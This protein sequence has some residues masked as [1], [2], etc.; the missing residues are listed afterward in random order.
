MKKSQLKSDYSLLS[1]CV[2]FWLFERDVWA[3]PNENVGGRRKKV[4]DDGIFTKNVKG[5]DAAA[6]VDDLIQ[7]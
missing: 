5:A 1:L 3:P 7:M 6:V 4:E 2:Y